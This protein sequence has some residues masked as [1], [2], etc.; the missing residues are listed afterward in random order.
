MFACDHS[1][2]STAGKGGLYRILIRNYVVALEKLYR[3]KRN[4]LQ[5]LYLPDIGIQIIAKIAIDGIIFI[6]ETKNLQGCFLK[7]LLG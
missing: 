7:L 2:G 5:R 4:L 1:G 3:K 6:L